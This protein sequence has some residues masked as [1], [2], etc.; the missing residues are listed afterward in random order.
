[1]AAT[2]TKRDPA[3]WAAAKSRAKA[4]MG[5]KHSARVVELT[6][7]QRK[8]QVTSFLNG[9][10]KTGAPSPVSRLL[11]G[12]K[13][14][15]SGTYPRRQERHCQARSMPQQLE[16]KEKIQK[17]ANSFPHSLKALQI[18]LSST[19]QQNMVGFLPKRAIEVVDL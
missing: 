5:G 19:G 12:L 6:Q 4:K 14:R 18:R 13:L 2:A 3:K 16:K 10:S 1:M 15:V 8:K 17:L 9:A 7:A 11:K